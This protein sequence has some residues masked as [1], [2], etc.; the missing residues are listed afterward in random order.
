MT[1][2]RDSQGTRHGI[3]SAPAVPLAL[4]LLTSAA[5][6]HSASLVA[7]G[8]PGA[9]GSMSAAAPSPDPR[10]GLQAG[11]TDAGEAAWN[12]RVALADAAVAAV[13][14]AS[15]T[16]T[17]R[18]T[19]KYAIQGSYNGY[20]VWDISDPRAPDAGDRLRLPRLAE[21]RLGLPEP[22]VRLGRGPLGPARLRHRGREGH[23]QHGAAPRA[24]D[25][26]HQRHRATRRT[27]ATCRPAAART[28]TRVL[29]DPQGHG[30]RL[31]LHLGLVPG[32]LAQRAARLRGRA[33][34]GGPQL[35]AVPDRGHQGAAGPSR[36]RRP[37]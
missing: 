24:P 16:P 4:A 36:S 19:G 15:P 18:F 22:A 32:A 25:L 11:L 7:R 29:V 5:C 14:R 30:Q 8:A 1:A 21:R 20:Q 37:S 26:R 28:P 27:S 3:R 12:L 6:A 9:G 31:R 34:V 35:G 2:P 23:G 33:A 10:V 13:R 17:W